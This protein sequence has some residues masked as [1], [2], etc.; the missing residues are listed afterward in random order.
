MRQ[1]KSTKESEM[2]NGKEAESYS[3]RS[4]WRAS[5]HFQRR[6]ILIQADNFAQKN[7]RANQT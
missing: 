3:G 6:G 7:L 4:Q 5:L 2:A 1:N